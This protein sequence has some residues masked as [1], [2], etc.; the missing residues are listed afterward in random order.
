MKEKQVITIKR[1]NIFIDES[2]N[3]G[4]VNGSSELY[5]VSF[6]I[7]ESDNSIANEL[8]YQLR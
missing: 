7:H 6:T 2:G 8:Q 1:L 4:F 5:A 3:F